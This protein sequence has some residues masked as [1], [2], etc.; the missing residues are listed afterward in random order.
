MCAMDLVSVIITTYKRAP[1]IVER[2]ICSV[3]KQTYPN[4]EIIVVDDSPADYPFRDDIRDIAEKYREKR[5]IR[6]LRHERNKGACAAR[7]TGIKDAKGRFICFL[8]DDDEYAATKVEKQVSILSH[9]DNV[10][11]IY[12]NCCVV[13]DDTGERIYQKKKFHK[14]NVYNLVLERNFIGTTSFPL[15]KKECL[16]SVGGFDEELPACQDY[17]MW[18]R[19]CE[20]YLVDFIDEPLVIYHNHSGDQITK[21]A[22]KRINALT[23]LINKN[24]EVLQ[25]N[26]KLWCIFRMKLMEEYLRENNQNMAIKLLRECFQKYPWLLKEYC[27]ALIKIS[28]NKDNR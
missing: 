4:L 18:I 25:K 22:G 20:R 21:N 14:G 2:A 1:Q 27:L 5:E 28:R 7:N 19:L 26:K 24:E 8:D 15:I 12:C 17:D 6:Y 9:S 23:R 16:V 10:G 11:L 3:V 13:D